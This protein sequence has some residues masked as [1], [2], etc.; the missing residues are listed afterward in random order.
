M[1][2]S[3]NQKAVN[4]FVKGLITEAAE[5]TF[6]EGASVD[7]LNCDLRRD[8]TRRRRLGV[9]YE[10]GYSLSGASVTLA[11]SSKLS[12]GDWINV[13]GNPDLEF[14]VVQKGSTLYFYNKADLPHSEQLRADTVDLTAHEFAGSAGAETV[15]C[16]YTSIKGVLVVSSPAINTIYVEYDSVTDTISSPTEINFKVRDFEYLGDVDDYTS[17]SATST[18]DNTRIYDTLNSGWADTNN[19]G[20]GTSLAIYRTAR[21]NLYPPLTHPWFSGK[22]TNDA[23]SVPEW[24]K[25]GA[26]TSLSGN[27][28]YVLDFFSKDRDSILVAEGYASPSPSLN[29]TETSR[30]RCVESFAGRV[31]YAGLDSS[32][33]SG[34]IIFSGLV[35]GVNDLGKCYQINDPTSEYSSDLLA[36]DGGTVKI[37]DAINIKKL[38]A[39]QFS[40]FVFADNGVWQITGT[41]GQ[42]RADSYIINRVSRVGLLSEGSFVFAEGLPFWWSR[43]GIHTLQTDTVS[44]QA[45]EKNISLSTI[46]TLWDEIDADAKQKVVSVYDNISKRIYWAYPDAGETVE[47]KLNNFL[48]FDVPLTAF[49]P[50]RVEDQTTNT[51]AIV[52]LSFYSGYGA[53]DLAL[54]VTSNSG[55]DDVVTSG[56]D[57]VI[58]TQISTFNTGDPAIVLICRDGATNQIT[59]GGFTSS[60]FLDWGDTDYSS[61]AITGYDFIGDLVRKKNAPYVLTYSRLTEEGFTGNEVDGYEAVRPSS[62]LISSAWDF[63]DTFST[64]QQAYRLKYPVTVDPN[65]LDVYNYPED[66]ITTRLKL[67][68]HGRSVRVKFESET[69]KDFII[70]GWGMIQGANPRF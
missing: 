55:L 57:D 67:R 39:Y 22:D 47:S 3:L 18:P 62:L 63:K 42:F 30:F 36:T 43:F 8:G 69:G 16:Q 51:N 21:S 38:Y 49:F 19:G 28:R 48:L 4:N 9:A 41:D 60:S 54:D 20:S 61:Y 59:M 2:Q 66:V 10:A 46:Q 44:G 12:S 68:G 13:G 1:P 7:E 34:T 58:S 17:Q 52:G 40:L 64:P 25:I 23:F 32:A 35:E 11:D 15:V 33:N 5:L 14:L 29:E 65:N 37:P 26:G 53:K 31:F 27:G 45:T 6:P 56:G 50:W 24:E 70:L